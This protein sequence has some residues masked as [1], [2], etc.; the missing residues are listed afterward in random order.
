MHIRII[1]C[2]GI[3]PFLLAINLDV[4]SSS[5]VFSNLIFVFICKCIIVLN[6]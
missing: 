2:V 6:Q 3:E 5:N 1:S 4:V